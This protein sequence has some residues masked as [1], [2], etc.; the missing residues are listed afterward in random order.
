MEDVSPAR[1]ARVSW[2]NDY[3]FPHF[4][5]YLRGEQTLVK[6]VQE[7]DSGDNV[8]KRIEYGISEVAGLWWSRTVVGNLGSGRDFTAH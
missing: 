1:F 5:R 7:I 3:K 4:V 8:F 2:A 6:L